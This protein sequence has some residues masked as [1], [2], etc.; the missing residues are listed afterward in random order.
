M[1]TFWFNYRNLILLLPVLIFA[2]GITFINVV[3]NLDPVQLPTNFTLSPFSLR[4]YLQRSAHITG[5]RAN[6]GI[7]TSSSQNGKMAW[8]CSGRTNAQ[9]ISNMWNAKL[10]HSDRVRDAMMSVCLPFVILLGVQKSTF[11]P[12]SLPKI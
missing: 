12:R 8:A 7:T 3:L 9:L 1:Q 6:R 5:T 11:D 2:Y 10:I 4:T